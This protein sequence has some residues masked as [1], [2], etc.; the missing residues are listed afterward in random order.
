MH[1]PRNEQHAAVYAGSKPGNYEIQFPIAVSVETLNVYRPLEK[2]TV[3]SS[4]M[5][6][7]TAIIPT[8]LGEIHHAMSHPTVLFFLVVAIAASVASAG[9]LLDGGFGET[10]ANRT[11]TRNAAA[12]TWR[13]STGQPYGDGIDVKPL[14]GAARNG[15]V[16]LHLQRLTVGTRS[17]P[18][19]C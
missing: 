8:I 15:K 7:I 16:G 10:L 3:V 6:D 11:I 4:P 12:G 19:H 1:F 14:A 13:I 17:G 2:P 18:T 9:E 5:Q